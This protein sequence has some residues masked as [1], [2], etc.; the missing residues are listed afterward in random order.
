M[1][2]IGFKYGLFEIMAYCNFPIK[3]W[4]FIGKNYPTLAVPIESIY[5]E[6]FTPKLCEMDRTHKAVIR[7]G[8][9][10]FAS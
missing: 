4:T 6:I 7:N 9:E 5:Q 8:A 3:K 10:V 1:L 2:A